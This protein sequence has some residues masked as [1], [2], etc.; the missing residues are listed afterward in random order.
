MFVYIYIYTH[1]S[2]YV[3]VVILTPIVIVAVI[4]L[5]IHIL[6]HIHTIV[7]IIMSTRNMTDDNTNH[8]D[9]N[10][11]N[12]N[13]MFNTHVDPGGGGT[14]SWRRTRARGRRNGGQLG[15]AL[16]GSLQIANSMFLTEVFVGH[17]SVKVFQHLVILRTCFPN[18]SK[19]ITFAAAPLGLTPFVSQP[20]WE[21]GEVVEV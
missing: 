1:T 6:Y 5:V 4:V 18:V 12:N 19:I 20:R 16:M 7:I 13:I 21:C 3:I 10:N 11:S 2:A 15:S 9:N 14:R 8:N 17:Q